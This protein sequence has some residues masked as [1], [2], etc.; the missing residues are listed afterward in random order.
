MNARSASTVIPRATA[1][2]PLAVYVGG[3]TAG[4]EDFSDKVG[5]DERESDRTRVVA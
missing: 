2:T 3:N 1:G 4:F 5:L